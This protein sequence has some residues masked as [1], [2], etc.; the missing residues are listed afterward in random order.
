MRTKRPHAVPGGR[1]KQHLFVVVA[2]SLLHSVYIDQTK[3]STKTSHRPMYTP[4]TICSNRSKAFRSI[5]MPSRLSWTTPN[6]I[7]NSML[8]TRKQ[9]ASAVFITELKQ[10]R[11]WSLL[12]RPVLHQWQEC[13]QFRLKGLY[14]F[15]PK[16]FSALKAAYSFM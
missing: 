3:N 11:I 7:S 5:W 4:V 13:S 1:P 10:V 2:L 14:R 9:N 15:P 12:P 16:Y 6:I 8:R